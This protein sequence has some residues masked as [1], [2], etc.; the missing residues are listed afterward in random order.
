V[1]TLSLPLNH[2]E[3][4]PN[5]LNISKTRLHLEGRDLS[6]KME[7]LRQDAMEID[8]TI[9]KLLSKNY[10]PITAF[11]QHFQLQKVDFKR[12]ISDILVDTLSIRDLVEKAL[13]A[14]RS[15]DLQI[16]ALCPVLDDLGLVV[17]ITLRSATPTTKLKEVEPEMI[18]NES[19]EEL[20]PFSEPDYPSSPTLR[21]LGLSSLTIGLLAENTLK[22]DRD[23]IDSLPAPILEVNQTLPTQAK[24]Q[25]IKTVTETEFLNLNALLQGQFTVQ[26]LNTVIYELNEM[27]TDKRYLQDSTPETFTAQELAYA[28]KFSVVRL[29]SVFEALLVLGRIELL[30]MEEECH[31]RILMI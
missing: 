25:L 5:K 9:S 26:Y 13:A 1:Q 8:T 17:D 24:S 2:P 22:K 6:Q 29:K 4:D 28:S 16:E 10:I 19:M 15:L 21:D 23:S 14:I 20:E 7:N 12:E 30:T 27:I 31:Y 3:T 11:D 18:M